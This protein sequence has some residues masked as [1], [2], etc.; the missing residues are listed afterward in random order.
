ML[1]SENYLDCS[2]EEAVNT[3]RQLGWKDD[4]IEVF[5]GV[6]EDTIQEKIRKHKSSKSATKERSVRYLGL[7]LVTLSNEKC[8]VEPEFVSSI[9]VVEDEGM[10]IKTFLETFY[11][12][13]EKLVKS[14]ILKAVKEVSSE[15]LHIDWEG[16]F[17]KRSGGEFSDDT[18][19]QLMESDPQFLCDYI[20]YSKVD[21]YLKARAITFLAATERPEYI[22]VIK[23]LVRDSKSALVRESAIKA[24]YSYFEEDL[25]SKEDLEK[26][27]YDVFELERSEPIKKEIR[28]RIELMSYL[29]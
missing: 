17:A 24:L 27:Y 13:N 1:H 5:T 15:F 20:Q 21:G 23:S 26:F 19:E 12:E 6:P 10:N 4:Q 9:I 25:I 11:K 29:I 16:E 2:F 18:L 28:T 7:F 8:P 14:L 22:G 3:I